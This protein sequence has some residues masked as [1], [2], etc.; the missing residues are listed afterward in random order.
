MNTLRLLCS[1]KDNVG[2]YLCTEQMDPMSSLGV[3]ASVGFI[4]RWLNYCKLGNFHEHF[5]FVKSVKTH[6]CDIKKLQQVCDLPTLV[7]D[8]VISSICEDFIFM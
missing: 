6:I 3:H 2:P 1:S 8:R 4:L 7:N 5:I